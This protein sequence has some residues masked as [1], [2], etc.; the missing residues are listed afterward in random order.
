MNHFM[1]N[2]YA[3]HDVFSWEESSL[4]WSNDLLG[5]SRQSISRNFGKDLKK[6]HSTN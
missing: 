6:K 5:N 2:Y 3:L 4:C 1:E